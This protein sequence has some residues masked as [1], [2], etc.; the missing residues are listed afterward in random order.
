[1]SAVPADAPAAS[2]SASDDIVWLQHNKVRLALHPL[3]AAGDGRP[4]LLLHGLGERSPEAVP[5]RVAAWPGPVWA[6]DFTGHGAS[7]V[8][9][10]GGYTCEFLMADADAALAHL[11][12]ATVHGRGLGGYVALLI[13]GGRPDLVRGVIIEDGPGLVGGG[14]DP[15]TPFVLPTPLPGEGAPDPYALLELSRDIRPPDYAATFARQAATLSGL[16]VAVAL[17]AVVRPPWA[18]AVAREP[19]VLALRL[20]R[21]LALFS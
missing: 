2:D 9:T 11:G 12:P 14:T 13:A 1:M 17:T 19:G 16:D 6:L 18:E 20:D 15:A 21:A 5:E 8:P 3:R 10:G 7:T 4:L